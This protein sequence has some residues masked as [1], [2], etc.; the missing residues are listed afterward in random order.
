MLHLHFFSLQL[1]SFQANR[2]KRVL[3]NFVVVCVEVLQSELLN[4]KYFKFQAT[5]KHNPKTPLLD[6]AKAA[7]IIVIIL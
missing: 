2:I 7:A 3:F 1:D 4:V 6:E 5:I